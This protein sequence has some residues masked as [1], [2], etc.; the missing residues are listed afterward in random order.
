MKL[1]SAT[2]E[3]FCQFD[4]LH[5]DFAGGLTAL[6][7]PNGSGKSNLFKG[8]HGAFTGG[9]DRNEGVKTDNIRQ[10]APPGSVSRATVVFEHA[11]VH[12]EL[13]R[14]LR[15]NNARLTITAHGQREVITKSGDINDRVLEILG[16]SG[17][18]LSDYVF[19]DQHAIF[20]FLTLQPAAR[21]A[22]F[23]RL[24]RT[25]QAAVL[26]KMLDKYCSTYTIPSISA[27]RVALKQEIEVLEARKAELMRARETLSVAELP[28]GDYTLIHHWQRK[29]Q[30]EKDLT[31][32]VRAHAAVGREVAHR[33]VTIEVRQREYD[34][35]NEDLTDRDEIKDNDKV[36]EELQ[37]WEVYNRTAAVRRT[38][39][40][41]LAEAKRQ[42]E[43]LESPEIPNELVPQEWTH[44]WNRVRELKEEF[45]AKQELLRRMKPGDSTCPTCGT[46]REVHSD[47]RVKL[48]QEVAALAEVV[49][50][51]D[52][53]VKQSRDYYKAVST[54]R[55]LKR[56]YEDDLVAVERDLAAYAT[57]VPKPW[58]SLEVLGELRSKWQQKIA[59]RDRLN[60]ELD[61]LRRDQLIS[62]SKKTYLEASVIAPAQLELESLANVTQDA[63]NAAQE[64]LARR[65]ELLQQRATNT[66]GLESVNYDITKATK[67]LQDLMQAEVTARKDRAWLDRVEVM[68]DVFHRDGLPKLTAQNYLA[69]I[70]EEVN[71][72]L[73]RFDAPFRVTANEQLSFVAH[74]PDGRKIVAGRLSG[75]EKVLLALAFRVAVNDIFAKDLGLLVLDEPTD[76]LDED[77]LNCLKIAVERLRELSSSRGLQVIIITHETG[78]SHLFDNTLTLGRK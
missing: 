61:N 11:G 26:H 52:I 13:T 36:D 48:E 35:I 62:T 23:Q 7:G 71:Q 72:L 27:D 49:R 53:K 32:A 44:W 42:L 28:S 12:A 34:I 15:P 14:G 56:K 18:M 46:P 76:G 20:D 24:F 41:E 69:V 60:A 77:N 59:K 39:E 3:N 31:E 70:Q 63:A 47:H 75:G 21:A 9:F 43:I 22:A 55:A 10:T 5:V 45:A 8:V 74:F 64:R 17:Q 29:Q 6:L 51:N 25:E 58:R 30:L 19:V 50:L 37:Q 73:S 4:H 16:V 38:L 40:T 66:A 67:A 2:M 57:D 54:Y 78:L 68:R 65:E 33:E 1:L